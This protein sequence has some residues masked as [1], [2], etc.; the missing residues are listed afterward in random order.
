MTI[1][2]K[3]V[4]RPTLDDMCQS[5][6]ILQLGELS[7]FV[8]AWELDDSAPL[9]GRVVGCLFAHVTNDGQLMSD[10]TPR[11]ARGGDPLS[12]MLCDFTLQTTPLNITENW[13]N[14]DIIAQTIKLK[15]PA[16]LPWLPV[17]ATFLLRGGGR[18]ARLHV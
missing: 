1:P 13:T 7:F 2:A 8:Y 3:I 11:C 9:S 14:L 6:N 18:I 12:P 16:T 5:R 15:V 17:H 10:G 4:V